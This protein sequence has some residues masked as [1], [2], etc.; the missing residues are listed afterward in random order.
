MLDIMLKAYRQ[1]G[2]KPPQQVYVSCNYCGKSISAYMDSFKRGRGP[3]G[4][5]GDNQ[6]KVVILT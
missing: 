2:D 3:Y 4:R 1:P 6:L 5:I